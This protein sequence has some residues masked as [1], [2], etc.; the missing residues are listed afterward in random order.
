M[1]GEG[2]RNNETTA[3]WKHWTVFL[4]IT[5]TACLAAYHF[6]SLAALELRQREHQVLLPTV[7]GLYL[8]PQS[9]DLGDVW[10]TPRHTFR[11]TIQNVGS[12]ARTIARFETTCGCLQLDPPGQ[13][14][15]PGDKAEFTAHL[16]LMRRL[17]YQVGV[18]EWPVSVRLNPVFKGDFA[19]T[20]GWEVKGVVHSR[21][22][23]NVLELAFEDRCTH[24]GPRIWRKVRAKA[25]MP[26]KSLRASVVPESAE[27]RV[28]SDAANPGDYLLFVSPNPSLPIGR[29][30]FEVQLQAVTLDEEVHPCSSIVAA[31]EMQPS[32]RAIPRMVLL[33]EHAIPAKVET[34]VT[35]RL[36]ANDWKIDHIETDTTET[37]VTQAKAELKEGV[38]LHITQR[39]EQVGDGV[40]TVRIVVR[41][42]DK[43]TE[44]VPVEV[45]YYGQNGP[46]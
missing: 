1:R 32:S 24:Q 33:G 8:E 4:L 21:V 36:P 19:S 38:R 5:P 3:R 43:Q 6:S 27:V 7:N 46:R 23:T 9:L 41:K 18:A 34:D 31:G 35:L 28:E 29:F 15:A 16:N 42:P 45:R 2:G 12:L 25:H 14:I 30:R 13:T 10:E 20:P 40:S 11:L 44:V 37:L 26:L 22:S 17:S 39:I